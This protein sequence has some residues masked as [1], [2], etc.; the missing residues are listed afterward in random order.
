MTRI[1]KKEKTTTEASPLWILVEIWL[2]FLLWFM[3]RQNQ[4][5]SLSVPFQWFIITA[6]WYKQ[7]IFGEK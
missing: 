4:R 3:G 6:I 1:Y 7:L 2:F 5:E